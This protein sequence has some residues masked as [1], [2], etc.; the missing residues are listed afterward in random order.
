MAFRTSRREIGAG[1]ER[2]G[3]IEAAR[4]RY[5]LHQARQTRSGYVNR[6]ARALRAGPLIAPAFVISRE[7]S[8][9]AAGFLIAAL[10]VLTIA[11]HNVAGGHS[12]VVQLEMCGDLNFRKRETAEGT[13]E[14]VR[15]LTA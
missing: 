12:F 14:I 6:R 2:S 15:S 8:G 5:C 13:L 9:F 4:C 1:R 11:F 10:I 7:F 3:A